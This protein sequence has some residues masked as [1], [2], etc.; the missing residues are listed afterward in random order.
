MASIPR[1]Q[2]FQ[3]YAQ[4]GLDIT[5]GKTEM[6]MPR[7]TFEMKSNNPKMLVT[8]SGK[9]ELRIN[10]DRAWDA[11]AIGDH[12]AY[13]QNVYQQGKQISLQGIERRVQNGD[14]LAAIHLGGNPIGE[15]AKQQ[16]F[17]EVPV[18]TTGPASRL[19]VDVQVNPTKTEIGLERGSVEL[20]S[21]QIPFEIS[22]DRSKVNL[23]LL[24]KNSLNVQPPQV[25]MQI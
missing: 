23:Y 19:N 8:S 9:A 16:A 4:I 1:I 25:D 21:Q 24:Q 13:M 17:A 11:M 12:L 18:Y 6:K 15:I 14:R 22:R 5:Q 2:I 3:Q 20:Q 10:Q 7:A